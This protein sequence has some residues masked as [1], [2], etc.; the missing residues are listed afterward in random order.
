[1]LKMPK[2]WKEE[3]VPPRK[4]KEE[5]R[6]IKKLSNSKAVERKIIIKYLNK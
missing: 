6:R 2:F 3:I 5:R 4:K 1:M